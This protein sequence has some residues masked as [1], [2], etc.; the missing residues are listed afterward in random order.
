MKP[1]DHIIEPTEIQAGDILLCVGQNEVADRVRKATKTKYTH[2]AICYSATEVA[3]ISNKIEK[4]PIT[5]FINEFKYI[6]VFRVP[7]FSHEL[8]INKLRAFIDRKVNSGASYDLE[9]ARRLMK[10]KKTHQIESFEKLTNHYVNGAP[11]PKHDKEK[12]ICSE[13]VT[14]ALIEAGI[15]GEGMA[16]GY[17]PD[18]LHPGNLGHDPSFGFLLGYLRSDSAIVIPEEDEF[19]CS[20]TNQMTYS[21]WQSATADLINNPPETDQKLSQSEI[22]WLLQFNDAQESAEGLD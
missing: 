6:A 2:A 4:V 3:H 7:D 19:A 10:R 12:Y 18:T 17:Q 20:M 5:E 11:E 15:W 16:S 1:N 14:S 8:N 9:A 21:E 13:I 22:Q